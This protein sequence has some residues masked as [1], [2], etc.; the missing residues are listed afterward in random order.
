M[1][2]KTAIQKTPN[3]FIAICKCG[4]IIG[5]MDFEKTDLSEAGEILALWIFAGCKVKPYIDPIGNEKINVEICTC[6]CI[7]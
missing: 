6:K 7:S 3:G 4:K 5:A 2:E 1:H